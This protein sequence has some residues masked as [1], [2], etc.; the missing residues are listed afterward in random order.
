MYRLVVAA[1]RRARM[2]TGGEARGD[3]MKGGWEIDHPDAAP[4]RPTP[5]CSS[6]FS[7]SSWE[8]RLEEQP[9]DLHEQKS[10]HV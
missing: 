1:G 8:T 2:W 5:G 6:S 4:P 9:I 10:H 3:G 7:E